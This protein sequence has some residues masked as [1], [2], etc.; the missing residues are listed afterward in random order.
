MLQAMRR[1][2][3]VHLARIYPAGYRVD[4]SNYDPQDLQSPE[5]NA[6]GSECFLKP[7]NGR[8]HVTKMDTDGLN[9]HDAYSTHRN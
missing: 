4:S 7:A 2:T 9:T 8:L 5:R 1:Y 3:A 6:F